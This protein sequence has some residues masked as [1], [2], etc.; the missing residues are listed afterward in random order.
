MTNL[1]VSRPSGATTLS[2]IDS[3]LC[4]TLVIRS[5]LPT[6]TIISYFWG[7]DKVDARKGRPC[8][9]HD[10]LKKTSLKK[11]KGELFLFVTNKVSYI[12]PMTV[13][14]TED[15]TRIHTLLT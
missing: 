6:H 15:N 12:Y 4:T 2:N 7:V 11:M 5:V 1:Q 3:S 8:I 14:I 10:I 13:D 9:A